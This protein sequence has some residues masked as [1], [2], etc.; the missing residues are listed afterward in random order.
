MLIAYCL[1]FLLHFAFNPSVLAF[2]ISGANHC[3]YFLCSQKNPIACK[4]AVHMNMLCA[5]SNIDYEVLSQRLQQLGLA[6]FDVGGAGDCFFRAVSHQYYATPDLHRRVRLSAI[7]HMRENS[8][9]YSESVLA[10]GY[11]WE[12]Y[13]GRMSTQGIWSDSIIVQAVANS[14]SA[15]IYIVHAFHL[16]QEPIIINP[17]SET[18]QQVLFIGFIPELHYVST[19]QI[20][21]GTETSVQNTTTKA[22]KELLKQ[23]DQK[24]EAKNMRRRLLYAMKRSSNLRENSCHK[25]PYK[26]DTLNTENHLPPKSVSK[27]QCDVT[28]SSDKQNYYSQFNA[29]T[30]TN[31]AEQHWAKQNLINFQK[32]LKFKTFHCSICEEAWP[33]NIPHQA[34]AGT[35]FVCLRCKRDKKHPKLFSSQNG[36]IPSKVPNELQ[37]LTST[38]EMLIA[39]ALPIINVYIKR[40][41]QRGYSGHCINLPQNVSELAKSLP[42]TPKDLAL[43]VVNIKGHDGHSKSLFVRRAVVLS[44]LQWLIDNNPLYNDV[45]IDYS[46]IEALPIAGIPDDLKTVETDN[47]M[48]EHIECD[49]DLPDDEKIH[50]HNTE[51]TSFF[52]TPDKQLRELDAI[53]QELS[54]ICD[55]IS[56]P[57][58]EN[59]PLNEYSTPF[60]ASMAFPTLFPDTKG[61]PT[62][63]SVYR[64]VTFPSRI[65][66]L[67]KFGENVH[68]KMK[69]RFASHPRFSYWALN[70]IQRKRALQQTGMYLKQNPGD[71]PVCPRDLNHSGDPTSVDRIMHKMS[72]YVAN[73]LGSH[74]YWQKQK[75]DLKSVI[76]K[77]G[78]GTIFFTFSAADM[79]WQDL[80]SMFHENPLLLTPQERRQNVIDNPHLTDWLFVQRLESFIKH[81]LYKTL[82]AEWHWY[83]YEYQ[84]RGSIH[85]HGIAK[86]KNDPGICNLAETALIGFKLQNKAEEDI[87]QPQ[88][89]ASMIQDGVHSAR[90]ICS[91]ADWLF[92]TFNPD[93]PEDG[94]WV[95]P[96]LHP[97]QHSMI[98][99]DPDQDLVNLINTVQRHT[100]CSSTYCLRKGKGEDMQCR[101]DFPKPLC[102]ETHLEFQK[103][104]LKHADTEYKVKVVTKRNDTRINNYQQLQL[105]G[106]RAN[107][108]IQLI[109]SFRDCVEYIT[110]YAA[111]GEPRSNAVKEAFNAIMKADGNAASH[112]TVL[113]KIVMKSLGQRDFSAQ[114]TMHHLLSLKL[115][116]SSFKVLPISLDGSRKIRRYVPS[117]DEEITSKSFMDIYANRTDFAETMDRE[118]ILTLNFDQFATNFKVVNNKLAKQDSNVIPKFYP[119]FSSN[120][121]TGK[122]G[123]YCRYQLIR[124]KPWLRNIQDAWENGPENDDTYIQQWI[125]FMSTDYAKSNVKDWTQ[126]M[127]VIQQQVLE[128]ST[129]TEASLNEETCHTNEEEDWMQISRL[130]RDRCNNTRNH[131]SE[132]S[133]DWSED[134]SHYT[135]QQ[136][137]EM[138]N[139][140]SLQKST[141]SLQE[142]FPSVDVSLFTPTQQYAYD[143][144]KNHAL[145][146]VDANPESL[147][148]IINGEAGTGKSFLISAIRNLLQ[149]QCYVTA[150]TGK[151]AHNINGVTIHSLLK[152]PVNKQQNKCLTGQSL[153]SLQEKFKIVKYLVID[154]YSMLG[155]RT[156]AWIDKRCRQATGKLDTL[157]GGI[158]MILVGDPAQLPPVADRPLYH[159]SP[160]DA[161]QEQGYCAYSF[162][163]KVVKLDS[164]MRLNGILSEQ[165]QFLN[166][167]T[168]L[169]K[170]N[171]SEEEWRLLLTRQPSHVSNLSDFKFATRLFFKNS[172]VSDFNLNRLKDLN[173]PIAVINAKHSSDEANAIPADEMSGLQQTI[174]IAKGAR[175]MLTMNLWTT[176]GLCNGAT[177]TVTDII[178]TRN[179]A[180]PSL[181]TAVVICFDN[182]QGPSVSSLPNCVPIPPATVSQKHHFGYHERQQLPLKLAWA[183]TIHKSQGL[184]LEKAWIDIGPT[185]KV[186]GITYVA[187]SRVRALSSCVIEPMSLDRL[188]VIGTCPTITFRIQE[189]IRLESLAAR[190]DIH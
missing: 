135:R 181:P 154:E 39:R 158:S 13:L 121:N 5:Q 91:Y 188:Q 82:D 74:A 67:I 138:H 167:L 159:S 165:C 8:A 76:S 190:T 118:D 172:D 79:H 100:R 162:F 144:I 112:A 115:V 37:G 98:D 10:H 107:C 178:Y 180:P 97:C 175:V 61:D 130:V 85:C 150:T 106:W 24:L 31:L 163:D 83:R 62:N 36:M 169:R 171:C 40:G 75:E 58:V 173:Q 125:H 114:E 119:Q 105:Q 94:N 103:I 78:A 129:N 149:Y 87:A 131:S 139:W 49:G 63:P 57:S 186:A 46:K 184:T 148:M 147:K 161:L 43:I 92:S 141:A 7:M 89:N 22:L 110:K 152:L 15:V 20:N 48:V 96:K 6:P 166:L 26:L 142:D 32:S 132:V 77:K 72:R 102:S 157:F 50:D 64:E 41:G 53:D 123:L 34:G 56:W 29:E 9:L 47:C 108:D 153:T 69:Y 35:S 99:T 12:T 70:M 155:Q 185:E 66:H 134:S 81:W 133:H 164:N 126:Q 143:I 2:Q 25:K 55:N 174:C 42:R 14:L 84:A 189:E 136:I 116:S 90:I 3:C 54:S 101:F 30:S 23:T 151:A 168:S 111:K 60:L 73:I 21:R 122:Y 86:L 93:P 68:G 176:A 16:S 33:S 18:R 124:Y 45:K 44:A 11:D 156:L 59:E 65:K 17:I 160:N 187:L 145:Q 109:L 52:S 146:S 51:V 117:E 177:G 38:E 127:E 27:K 113:K 28:I 104:R 19:Q 4:K 1:P 140:I 170:G 137:G 71:T 183:I 120:R 88:G 80:H 128:E 95:K 179:Q 182:Y